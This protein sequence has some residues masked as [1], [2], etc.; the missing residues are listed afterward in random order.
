LSSQYFRFTVL[1]AEQRR[2]GLLEQLLVRADAHV[3]AS[4][5]R[6]EAF[7]VIAPAGIAMPAVAAAAL[8]ADSGAVD[9]AWVCLA[10]P[11]HYV[12]EM[13][14]VRLSQDGI[15]ALSPAAAEALAADFNRVWRGAGI[16]LTAARSGR[17]Y[18][19]FDKPLTVSTHDPREAL[20]H[21]I[22]DYLPAGEG[23]ATL[24]QLISETEMW[25]FQQDINEARV[26]SGEPVVNGLWFWGG[27]A[28]LA[29]LPAVQGWVGG[30]DVFFN[31][32]GASASVN[33]GTGSGVVA[34]SG[35]PGGLEWQD[36]ESRWLRPAIAQLR[37]GALS[38]LEISVK[39]WRFVLNSRTLRRFWRRR[40]A[41]WEILA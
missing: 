38:R 41:W 19:L 20:G 27:G 24:R 18:C 15:L 34:V 30:E 26:K 1:A 2:S 10:T 3:S 7:G 17:L 6:A 22:E 32:F 4:D 13:A 23:S 28:P 40:K 39:N 31:A 14:T 25:L 29:V 11:V 37:S 8:R 36:I 9:A 16:S 35:A 5:W 12:A 33:P 21:S